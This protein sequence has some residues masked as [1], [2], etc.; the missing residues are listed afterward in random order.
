MKNLNKIKDLSQKVFAEI[1]NNDLS[2]A[3]AALSFRALM[4][5]IPTSVLIV[6]VIGAILGQEK[7]SEWLFMVLENNFGTEVVVLE[8]ALEG[9]FGLMTG[10]FFSFVI[11]V[12]VLWSSVSLIHHTRKRFFIIFGL[13]ISAH[14][15]LKQSIK[16]RALSFLYTLLTFVLIMIIIIGQGVIGI[17]SGSLTETFEQFNVPILYQVVRSIPFFLLIVSV[18]G[19]IY[20]FMSAGTLRFRSILMGSLT[21]SV[22]FMIFNSLV[23]LYT[24]YSVNMGLF[25]AYS[26]IVVLLVWFY[27][28]AY[29]LFLGGIVASVVG[30]KQ[31]KKDNN[32]K[33]VYI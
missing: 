20:W 22:L 17:L 31:L 11:L 7:V 14:G 29:T 24:S 5:I 10:A 28:S 2:N 26:F 16:S 1:E 9:T 6:L 27:Y 13:N 19:L 15:R 3:A 30:K 32:S 25:G 33:T 4:A 21:S 23:S 12:V 18:F 8:N